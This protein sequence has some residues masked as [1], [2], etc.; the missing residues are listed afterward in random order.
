MRA[1]SHPVRLLALS[2]CAIS[3]F[4]ASDRRVIVVSLDG[5]PAYA[6]EDP[7]LPMPALRRLIK[8]GASA[9]RMTTV[10]PT[11][12]WPNHTAMS[13][14]V[15]PGEHGVYVNGTIPRGDAPLTP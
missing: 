12:T 8:E 15:Y 3:L 13:T 2:F 9:A 14:G 11:V 1:S 4:A 10:N 6:L 5:L 7:N